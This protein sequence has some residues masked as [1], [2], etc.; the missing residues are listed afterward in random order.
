MSDQ[1]NDPSSQY[2][3][4]PPVIG[5]RPEDAFGYQEPED[6]SQVVDPEAEDRVSKRESDKVVK[7][8]Q[9]RFKRCVDWESRAQ[10][11]FME[12]LR[13][14]EGDSD[15][16]FQWPNEILRDR[17][18]DQQP[19]LTINKAR[20]HC[21][22]ILNDARKNKPSIKFR[23]VGDGATYASA[24]VMDGICRHIEYQSNAQAIYDKATEFQ[25]KGGIGYWRVT[26]DYVDEMSFEQDIFIRPISNPLA[27]YLDPDIQE[28][29]GSDAKFGFIFDEIPIGD[30]KRDHPEYKDIEPSNT[31]LLHGGGE[32]TV[33]HR[34][35]HV[36]IAEYY[37][38]EHKDDTLVSYADPR[39]GKRSVMLESELTGPDGDTTI[40]D[41][42]K[43]DPQTFTRPTTRRQVMWYKI[44]GDKAVAKRVWP[45]KYVPIVRV[46]GEETVVDGQLDRKGHVRAMK[47]PQRMYNYWASSATAQVALQTKVPYVGPLAAFEN[48]SGYWE[49][50]NRVNTPFLPYNHRDD[51]G[52]EVPRPERVPPPVMSEAYIQGM[53]LASQELMAV[54]GQ[55]QSQMGQQGNEVSGKAINERQRQS[56]TSTYH[57][58]DNLALAIRFTGKIV[59]DLIPKIYDTERVIRILGENGEEEQ[60]QIDPQAPQAL[61]QQEQTQEQREQAK[62]VDAVT[63]VLNPKIGK[64]LV[65]ADVG[66]AYSTRRQETFNALTQIITARPELSMLIGDILLKAGDFPMADEAAER[67]K[68]MVPPQALGDAPSQEVIN[69]QQMIQ[70]LQGS[71]ASALQALANKDQET[72][73][74]EEKN[75]INLYKAQTDR[76]EALAEAL[77]PQVIAQ[78][79][80]GLVLGM[81]RND[82][83]LAA[84]ETQATPPPGL[85]GM[86]GSGG[87]VSP[88]GGGAVP[89]Q[90]KPLDNPVPTTEMR[91]AGQGTHI[92]QDPNRPGGYMQVQT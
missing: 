23:A 46:I 14:A 25:V 34:E 86:A 28:V 24:Q 78:A 91:R 89:E 58:V 10:K 2:F 26:T 41:G 48:L 11:L 44:V 47:D 60:V 80:A 9:E 69:L 32:L 5:A 71:L 45:S 39:T 88:G 63:K 52:N 75:Q 12:D 82:R 13:F 57:Y 27:V 37:R 18:T 73:Q 8:A 83:A 51:E 92:L 20:Q 21:L 31:V 81:V 68:R 16:N 79:V 64:Y 17:E 50:A 15:N 66:P 84:V 3:Q 22:L 4:A 1:L 74:D 90:I 33:W 77:N 7:E 55:Y 85:P 49:T 38:V 19:C 36:V 62:D 76:L 65:H 53:A 54:S 59:L 70:N 72:K 6:N 87:G 29:D 67:M 56:D 42:L 40:L 30:F 61:Q 35:E 43:A